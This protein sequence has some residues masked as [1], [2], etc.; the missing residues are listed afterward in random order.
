MR[1]RLT[2]TRAIRPGRIHK[3]V[4]AREHATWRD[5]PRDRRLDAASCDR[6][7]QRADDAYEVRRGEEVVAT[8]VRDEQRRREAEREVALCS[9]GAAAV[10][11]RRAGIDEL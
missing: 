4:S 9:R 7:V 8:R 5:E 2:K 11:I 6:L 10:T 3:L 1:P